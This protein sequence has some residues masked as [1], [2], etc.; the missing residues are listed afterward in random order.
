MLGCPEFSGRRCFKGIKFTHTHD[1]G[2]AKI[3]TSPPSARDQG[4][5]TAPATASQFKVSAGKLIAKIALR[6]RG[7][8]CR[9]DSNHAAHRLRELNTE[10]DEKFERGPNV[11]IG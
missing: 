2:T 10:S 5:V 4:P 11:R 7:G 8:I 1:R 6:D 3:W 9:T